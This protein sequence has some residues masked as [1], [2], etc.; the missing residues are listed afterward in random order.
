MQ[1]EK[2]DWYLPWLMLV[3]YGACKLNFSQFLLRKIGFEEY[4]DPQ[5][6]HCLDALWRVVCGIYLL[7]VCS[8]TTNRTMRRYNLAAISLRTQGG[9]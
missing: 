1:L 6:C 4:G 5:V 7:H 2:I 8:G 3:V 9:V